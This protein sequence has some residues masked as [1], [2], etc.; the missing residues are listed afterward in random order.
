[1]FS[2]QE[3]KDAKRTV[4]AVV[5]VLFFIAVLSLVFLGWRYFTAPV[6]GVVEAQEQI[7]RGANR[8]QEYE[9]FFDLCY[10]AKATQ[11]TI[12][13]QQALLESG[14][15]HPDQVRTTITGL[16]ARLNQ[17]VNEYNSNSHKSYTSAQFKASELPFEINAENIQCQ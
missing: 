10:S 6:K 13:Q 8:I 14:A 12:T 15:K 16:Q 1:M 3:K 9:K 5:I 7:H 4:V 2:N 17:I 11:D